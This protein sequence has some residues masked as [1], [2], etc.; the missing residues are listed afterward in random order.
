MFH[1]SFASFAND[2]QREIEYK[3]INLVI[4]KYGKGLSNRL[5]GTG[6]NPSY[7]SWYENECF[8]SVAAGTYQEFNWSAMKWFSVNTCSDYAEILETD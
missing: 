7:R 1:F 5:K 8:V 3:A 6:L 4:Q 2:L